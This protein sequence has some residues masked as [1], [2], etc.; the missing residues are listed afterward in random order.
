MILGYVEKSKE[1]RET[2][3][4]FNKKLHRGRKWDS[5]QTAV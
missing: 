2:L 4:L 1:K 5:P 3:T